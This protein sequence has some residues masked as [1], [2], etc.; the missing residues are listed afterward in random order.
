MKNKVIQN[1][2]ELSGLFKDNQVILAGGFGLSGAPLTI[3]DQMAETDVKGLHVVSNNLGDHGIGLHKLFLQGKIEKAIGSFFTMNREAVIAWS[4][5][6]LDIELLPQ[7][8]LAEAIRCGGAGIG[9]FYT[10]TAVGTELAINKEERVIDGE[11]YIFEKAIK[12]DVAII[13]AKAAD[14]LGN[15]IYHTTARNFNP[16]MATAAETVIVEVDE[17]LEVGEL[18]P[19]AIVTPHVYVDYIVQS[20]YVKE[21]D[22][23]VSV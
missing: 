19:E 4:E 23:Y 1:L 22:R 2:S 9:G 7:G 14:R 12:G 5:G 15:L 6:K 10:K 18:D 3:I 8:T 17:I 21:G 16:M 20:N 11:T 13:R